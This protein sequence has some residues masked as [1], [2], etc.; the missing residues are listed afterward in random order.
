MNLPIFER[1]EHFSGITEQDRRL[2]Y[3]EPSRCMNPLRE[4]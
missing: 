3:K 2:E 4:G 1:L